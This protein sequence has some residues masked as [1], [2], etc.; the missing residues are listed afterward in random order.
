[1][2]LEKLK[3]TGCSEIVVI[4]PEK[5]ALNKTDKRDA[6]ALGALLWNDRKL[7][8]GGK[9]RRANARRS[10]TLSPLFVYNETQ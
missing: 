5:S 8:Q 2:L 10:C 9:A 7:L 4:Q 3:Q 1:W 6:D